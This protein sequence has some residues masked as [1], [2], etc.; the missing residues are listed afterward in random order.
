ML[1]SKKIQNKYCV[2]DSPRTTFTEKVREQDD[3]FLPAK[4]S[5]GSDRVKCESGAG[6]TLIEM[7]MV[8]VIFIV[9]FTGAVMTTSQLKG[10]NNKQFYN[11]DTESIQALI[12]KAHTYARANRHNDNWGIKVLYANA[13]GCGTTAGTNCFILF[14]GKDY[15]TRDAEYDEIISFSSQLIRNEEVNTESELY[16][17][18]V[19]GFGR[20]FDNA[21]NTDETGFRLRTVDGSY[22][23]TVRVGIFGVVYNSCE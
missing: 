19:T 21:S 3:V 18:Q 5:S 15:A 6:F 8:I 14:K 17:Q 1:S 13:T 9:L 22:D 11:A 12:A 16:Y 2:G 20:G 23:C 4:L 10:K 7:I